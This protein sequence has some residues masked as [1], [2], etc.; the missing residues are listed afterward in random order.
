M[1]NLHFLETFVKIIEH[2]S[3][4]KTA[5]KLNLSQSAISQQIDV[6]ENYFGARLFER[7]IKGVE[8]TEEGRILK[9]YSEVILD[10][11]KLAKLEIDKAIGEFRGIIRLSSSTIPGE[12]ILPKYMIKFKKQFPSVD[13]K[14]DVND[15][16]ISLNR[17]L[18]DSVDLAAVGN[19]ETFKGLEILELAEEELF[20]VVPKDHELA[21]KG[22]KEVDEIQKY[23][24]I[25]REKTSGTRKESEKILKQAGISVENLHIVGELNTTESILTAISEGLGIS[26]VSSIAAEKLEKSGAIKCLRLPGMTTK[27]KLYLVKKKNKDDTANPL[28]A[29]F[30]E[31]IRKEMI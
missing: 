28:V 21:Q 6:L 31:F 23:P 20:L 18:E 4:S 26:L 19:L 5:K 12:H 30:W 7:S 10:S 1:L 9:K 25:F 22:I 16:E 24:F 11:I 29:T 2:G 14:V 13:F 15:S 17:L 3:F 27:R 8:L